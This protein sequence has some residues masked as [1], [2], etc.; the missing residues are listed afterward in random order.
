MMLSGRVSAVHSAETYVDKTQR[1]TIRVKDE[2]PFA[3]FTIRN[4]AGLRLDDEV[5]VVVS[6]ASKP[7]TADP[8]VTVGTLAAQA[9]SHE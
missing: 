7:S 5:I 2:G 8:T 3:S 6:R 4:D 9:A 1:V